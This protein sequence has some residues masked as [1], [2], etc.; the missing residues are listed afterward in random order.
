MIIYDKKY[1]IDTEVIKEWQP[2]KSTNTTVT[3]L[4]ITPILIVIY[5][6]SRYTIWNNNMNSGKYAKCSNGSTE[7]WLRDDS[8][9]YFNVA[10]ETFTLPF[11]PLATAYY[12][13]VGY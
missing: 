6:E 13:C 12:Y 7:S 5:N 1:Q 10:S 9:T 3:G 11:I 8:S 2:V 4:G